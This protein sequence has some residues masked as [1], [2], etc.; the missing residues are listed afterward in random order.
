MT[1]RFCNVEFIDSSQQGN[2]GAYEIG[3]AVLALQVALVSAFPGGLPAGLIT[4]TEAI[5]KTFEMIV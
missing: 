3:I 2:K 4:R 5:P 1:S